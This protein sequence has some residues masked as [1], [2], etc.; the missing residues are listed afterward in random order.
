MRKR[1]LPRPLHAV[2]CVLA[3]LLILGL[4]RVLCGPF[5]A[6]SPEAWVRRQERQS[7]L[8]PGEIEARWD[9]GDFTYL[10]L[11]QPGG[12][13]RVYGTV[14]QNTV[15]YAGPEMKPR[16]FRLLRLYQSNVTWHA[17]RG[18][19]PWKGTSFYDH[20]W[21]VTES[22]MTSVLEAHLLFENEDPAVQRA[23]FRCT[24]VSERELADPGAWGQG[25]FGESRSP[26]DGP[27]REE[28]PM[29]LAEAAYWEKRY[30]HTGVSERD[31]KEVI[32]QTW[33]AASERLTSRLFDLTLTMEIE[34]ASPLYHDR[35]ASLFTIADGGTSD[36][37]AGISVSL[38]GEVIWQDGEGRELYRERIGFFT[39]E[40]EAG[41]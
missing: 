29:A 10:A 7:L 32:T 20:Y 38:E 17:G 19:V 12:A 41:A 11:R 35:Q 1:C 4:V 18:E 5:A 33:Q 26:G 2:F 24:A 40:G 15:T 36:Y 8:P 27:A 31:G 34:S 30:P 21:D 23:E 3:M 14:P 6:L 39:G 37:D 9:R 25:T 13:W 28:E 22:G 16:G